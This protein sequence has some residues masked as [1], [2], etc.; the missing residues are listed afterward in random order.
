[1]H[2]TRT[3]DRTDFPPLRRRA[4]CLRSILAIAAAKVVCIATSTGNPQRRDDTGNHYGSDRLYRREPDIQ[5]IDMTGGAPELNPEFRRLVVPARSR[6]LK[7]IDRCNLTIL[8][9]PGFED[10]ADFMAAHKVEIVASLPC[11]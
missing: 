10:M 7:V 8:E 6:G 11:Y 2:A 1:M 9:E 3:A 4:M 5:T